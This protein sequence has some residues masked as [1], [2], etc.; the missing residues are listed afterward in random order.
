MPKITISLLF[1]RA[2]ANGTNGGE[3][4]SATEQTNTESPSILNKRAKRI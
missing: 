4:M 1:R 3:L 2:A